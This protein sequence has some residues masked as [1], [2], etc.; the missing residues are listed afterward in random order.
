MSPT[1]IEQV[2]RDL[3]TVEDKA[4]AVRNALMDGV[5]VHEEALLGARN[6]LERMYQIVKSHRATAA[7]IAR[8][9]K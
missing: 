3:G 8:N 6:L 4:R 7:D 9:G 2:I 1:T 5:L